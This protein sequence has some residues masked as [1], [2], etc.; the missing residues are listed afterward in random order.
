VRLNN[1]TGYHV[2]GSINI[3]TSGGGDSLESRVITAI[4]TVQRTINFSS[5][6]ELEHA[7]GAR[8]TGSGNNVA[9]SDP[10]AGAAG[11]S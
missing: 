6:L 11:T 9:A 10:S 3:N 4:D 2:Q 8:V 5:P 1:V 7:A